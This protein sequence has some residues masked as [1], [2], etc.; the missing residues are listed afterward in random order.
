MKAVVLHSIE[1]HETRFL[2]VIFLWFHFCPVGAVQ[3]SEF[4]SLLAKASRSFV[5]LPKSRASAVGDIILPSN[6]RPTGY[7]GAA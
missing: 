3:A 4:R 7:V 5:L 6:D 1:D 2:K